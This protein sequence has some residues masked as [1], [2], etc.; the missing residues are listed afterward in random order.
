MNKNNLTQ[1]EIA[2][3]AVL[4]AI[5]LILIILIV[6]VVK[7]NCELDKKIKEK[8][9]SEKNRIPNLD[10][11]NVNKQEDV[12][13]SED[14]FYKK[15]N[16]Q[17][18]EQA[19]FG[20]MLQGTDSRSIE[21]SD[22][23]SYSDESDNSSCNDEN[24]ELNYKIQSVRQRFKN[25]LLTLFDDDVHEKFKDE[26]NKKH[27]GDI[28]KF[29]KATIKLLPKNINFKKLNDRFDQD[30]NHG[31]IYESDEVKRLF[32]IAQRCAFMDFML[33]NRCY[34]E[35]KMPGAIDAT[36]FAISNLGLLLNLTKQMFD[37]LEFINKTK[38]K[39]FENYSVAYND[40]LV[41]FDFVELSE[42]KKSEFE[43]IK[44]LDLMKSAVQLISKI[45]IEKLKEKIS[46]NLDNINISDERRNFFQSD[47][48]KLLCSLI[49][50]YAFLCS[51]KQ[52]LLG[53]MLDN[54][55]FL[56]NQLSSFLNARDKMIDVVNLLDE[57][58]EDKNFL[59]I[60]K[61]ELSQNYGVKIIED[62]LL[63]RIKPSDEYDF[64]DALQ[65]LSNRRPVSV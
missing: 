24:L 44:L 33:K 36:S 59:K 16:S 41:K 28:L 11:E 31:A 25:S 56:V 40:S 60:L 29:V 30:Q 35:V 26:L 10:A 12:K 7:K 19:M 48:A 38:I 2:I 21:H 8:T 62:F 53:E 34:N 20:M 32:L 43:K 61:E 5:S 58:L 15:E 3:L 6:I 4:L 14:K 45:N 63:Q 23:L 50:I 52:E 55:L 54:K 9:E 22:D 13:K 17:Q 46:K 57:C 39:L 1:I 65:K 18:A 27:N 51:K 64:K 42:G 47:E 37:I 49:Q